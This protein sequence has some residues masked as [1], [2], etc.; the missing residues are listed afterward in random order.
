[1]NA[2]S[3]R[4]ATPRAP[5]LAPDP[6]AHLAPPL[7]PEEDDVAGDVAIELDRPDD[8]ARVA[9][10]R[11]PVRHECVALPRREGGHP[12]GHGVPLVLEEDR[13]VVLG[14]AAQP[15]LAGEQTWRPI[16]R[17]LARSYVRPTLPSRTVQRRTT[18]GGSSRSAAIGTPSILR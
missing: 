4:V 3:A 13:K 2:E 16:T 9:Q 11:T 1:M 18:R 8:D 14:H 17:D 7:E 15:H 12:V 6:V 5:E 10:D